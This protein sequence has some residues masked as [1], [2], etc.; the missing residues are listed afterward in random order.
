MKVLVRRHPAGATFAVRARPKGGSNAVCGEREGAV[1]VRITAA[2]EKGKANT[3][4]IAVL[5]R[6]LGRSRSELEI[7]AGETSANKVILVRGAEASELELELA[8]LVGEPAT[9]VE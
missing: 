5:A 8:A 4:I 6:A 3:A 7:L 2:P 1:L 9:I